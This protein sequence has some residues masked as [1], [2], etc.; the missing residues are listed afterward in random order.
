MILSSLK[1]YSELIAATAE[2]LVVL[3][4]VACAFLPE[5]DLVTSKVRHGH[6][7]GSSRLGNI[8]SVELYPR[9]TFRPSHIDGNLLM[10]SLSSRLQA[11]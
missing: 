9:C 8:A 11:S 5:R 6:V 3:L 4:L 2:R 10:C 7:D 1:S